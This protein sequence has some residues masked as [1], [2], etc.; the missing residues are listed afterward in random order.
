MQHNVHRA[1]ARLAT[2]VLFTSLIASA[3][4]GRASASGAQ[5]PTPS[6]T[7]HYRALLHPLNASGVSGTVQL[8]VTGSM[9]L[10]SIQAR[11]LEPNR[12]HYQH[13]HGNSGGTVGCP[14]SAAA[15]ASGVLT[16]DQGLAVV[17]PIALD[18]APYPEVRASG[19]VNWSHTYAL[20]TAELASLAPLTGHVVVLHGLTAHD[21][22]YDR[23]LFVACGPIQAT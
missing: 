19:S 2:L 13:I 3:G 6:T 12:E 20:T 16:V 8:D 22:I 18:L 9:L 4:C 10:V 11:G 21:G 7:G 14:S 5:A 1:V 17:G 15:D 23:A